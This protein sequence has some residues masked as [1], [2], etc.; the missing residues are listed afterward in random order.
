MLPIFRVAQPRE[1]PSDGAQAPLPQ[2]NADFMP[3]IS[4]LPTAYESFIRFS[5]ILWLSEKIA[6]K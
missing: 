3:K 6:Y 2:R 5:T 4:S 1:R